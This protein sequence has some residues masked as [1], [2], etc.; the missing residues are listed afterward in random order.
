MLP[1]LAAGSEA[2]V[3]VGFRKVRRLPRVPAEDRRSPEV[4]QRMGGFE[5]ACAGHRGKGVNPGHVSLVK[6]LRAVAHRLPP[7]EK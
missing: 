6:V 1:S 4:A 7:S 5:A 3:G 2:V